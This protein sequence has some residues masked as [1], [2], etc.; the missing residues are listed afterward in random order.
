MGRSYHQGKVGQQ[1]HREAHQQ[2]GNLQRLPLAQLG[3][4][5]WPRCFVH[6]PNLGCPK[7]GPKYLTRSGPYHGLPEEAGLALVAVFL[8]V[9]L[10][11]P[12]TSEENGES[13][14]AFP[15]NVEEERAI[16]EVA[17]IEILEVTFSLSRTSLSGNKVCGKGPSVV[18]NWVSKVV[19]KVLQWTLSSDDSLNKESKHGEHSKSTILD[20]LYLELSKSLWVISKAQWVK[21]TTRVKWVNNLTKRSTSNTVTLNGSHQHNLASPNCQDA[22]CM[23]QTWVAQV[24]KSTL[25]ENLGSS[26]EPYSFAKLD[27]VTGQKLRE[28][29]SKSTKH[30]PSAVDH[31]QF[32]VLSECFRLGASPE[33]G[34]KYLTRSGPYHGL[35]EEAGLALAALF[36]MVT[37][38]FPVISEEDSESFT[39]FPAKVEEERAIVE[40]AIIKF[41]ANAQ[42]LLLTGSARWS[43]SKSAIL[44]FLNL[45]LSKSLWVISKA[46]WVKAT[47][48][49]KW[50]NN[51]TK[52]PTSNTVTFNSSHQHNLA[53]PDSQ[54]ALCM[55]QA[56]VAQV[57]ESTLAENLRSSLEPYSFTK[58]DTVTGQ[59]LRKDTS[60]SS[61]HGPSAVDHLQFTVLGECFRLGASP[62]NGPKYLT[63]SGPYHGLPEEAG[64]ALAAVFLMVILP[65]PV[66]SEKDGESFTAFPAKVEEERAIVEAAIVRSR[67]KTL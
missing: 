32:T 22:L 36:L 51:L 35:P 53:S 28:D 42:A 49:V 56:W 26:L 54:D 15:T 29:T 45:E 30:G 58:L 67:M 7:N 31:L 41:V 38:P 59:K 40:A 33:N 16:V 65:F 24:V 12:V 5:K 17:I 14:T 64:L 19:G 50:V 37:L 21:A 25:A 43:A 2:Y 55:D 10:P 52:R 27:T 4:P 20:F 61:K 63:R 11:F 60:K 1:P 3:K 47:T 6:G 48:R 57:V 13:F 23:D 44:D 39:A 18:V 34:P 8:M 66:I 46:Q 62:E 9:T